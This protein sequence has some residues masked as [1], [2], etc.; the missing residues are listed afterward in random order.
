MNDFNP[1][2]KYEYYRSKEH[3]KNVRKIH[4]LGCGVIGQS[5]AAHS[6]SGK[7]GKGMRIKASD[8]FTIPLCQNCHRDFDHYSNLDR[9]KSELYFLRRLEM[10][11]IHL[12]QFNKL[13]PEA[14]R[15]LKL[16]GVL[17]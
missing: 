13:L 8:E 12:R 15:L 1:Q 4:C 16:R 10:T 6:N 14:E 7:H 2:P 3:L 17:E 9:E 5:Q 11:I